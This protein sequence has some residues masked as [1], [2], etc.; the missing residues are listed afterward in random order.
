MAVTS[1]IVGIRTMQQLEDAVKTIET[2]ELSDEELRI[3]IDA[4][5]VNVYEQHR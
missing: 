5:P 2:R 1:A 3:L 4:I